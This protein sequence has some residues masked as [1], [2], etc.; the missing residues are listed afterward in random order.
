MSGSASFA[1]LV[2]ADFGRSERL[3]AL[4]MPVVGD[5][6]L[7]APSFELARLQKRVRAIA[8]PPHVS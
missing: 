6:V 4:V 3:I 5:P 8:A 7:L 2:G 1:Y